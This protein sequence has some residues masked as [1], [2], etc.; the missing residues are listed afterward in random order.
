MHLTRTCFTNFFTTLGTHLASLA[1]DTITW[2]GTQG[3][4]PGGVGGWS[5]RLGLPL[6]SDRASHRARHRNR[7]AATGRR[8]LAERT[9][10]KSSGS[11][12]RAYRRVPSVRRNVGP[13]AR[14]VPLSHAEVAATCGYPGR[15]KRPRCIAGRM[16][17]H[18]VPLPQVPGQSPRRRQ[19]GNY[20]LP[21]I[22]LFELCRTLRV[23]HG[24]SSLV[25][26]RDKG[27]RE[28]SMAHHGESIRDLSCSGL[29]GDAAES[30]FRQDASS[31]HMDIS[32]FVADR[33]SR[34]L[35]SS[36]RLARMVLRKG[37]MELPGAPLCYEPFLVFIDPFKRLICDRRCGSRSRRLRSARHWP[38]TFCRCT[39]Y[40]TIIDAVQSAAETLG[41]GGSGPKALGG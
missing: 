26:S 25:A 20:R 8:C 3:I 14:Y 13:P 33:L 36:G 9:N 40:K 15:A 6:S 31:T 12:D 11:A 30:R 28:V 4:A 2:L 32:R 37:H 17:S 34:L 23:R 22:T 16:V 10:N 7:V 24:R 35:G 18:G 39:G 1:T 19:P 29:L 21:T 38:A 5:H 27:Q 41:G